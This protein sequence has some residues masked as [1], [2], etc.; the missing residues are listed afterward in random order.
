MNDKTTTNPK[1]AG[2]PYGVPTSVISVRIPT[3]LKK[4]ADERFGN[5]WAGMF[6]HFVEVY[7]LER[8][9]IEIK[10]K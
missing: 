10:K 8:E 7:L 2:R 5:H 3:E 4:K 6:R 9:P 1:K